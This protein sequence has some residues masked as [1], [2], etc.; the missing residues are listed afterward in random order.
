MTFGHLMT[1][2]LDELFKLIES[3]SLKPAEF[4]QQMRSGEWAG[5]VYSRVPT[6]VHVPSESFFAFMEHPWGGHNVYYS[7]G[8]ES[9]SKHIGE[10]EWK[11]VKA[12]FA[13]WLDSV[14]RETSAQDLWRALENEPRTTFHAAQTQ[15]NTPFRLQEQQRIAATMDD[16]LREV[17][18]TQS[19]SKIQT[20]IIVSA[21]EDLKAA[22]ARV[23][24]KDWFMILIGTFASVIM[25]AVITPP[26]VRALLST[27]VSALTWVVGKSESVLNP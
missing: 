14:K 24:R 15:D 8:E 11:S 21:V 19:L 5:S 25:G 17:R 23:G 20:D 3:S 26:E 22:S 6:L 2:Q 18:R 13:G 9:K 27:S 12:Y 16:V 1:S 4:E 10:L 7:P